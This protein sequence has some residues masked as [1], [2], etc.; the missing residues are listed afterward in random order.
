MIKEG[1][2]D[3]RALNPDCDGLRLPLP[4]TARTHAIT[5]AAA[6]AT[7]APLTPQARPLG[8]QEAS[9]ISCPRH[10]RRAPFIVIMTSFGI[11]TWFKVPLEMSRYEILSRASCFVVTL[12]TTATSHP[13]TGAPTTTKS[14]TTHLITSQHVVRP[15]AFKNYYPQDWISHVNDERVK[16]YAEKRSAVGEVL[17]SYELVGEEEA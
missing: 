11:S 5:H 4:R 9:K 1:K 2:Q 3:E 8:P 14:T 15:W 17:E 7:A 16:F 6:T 12:P 10:F 13:S